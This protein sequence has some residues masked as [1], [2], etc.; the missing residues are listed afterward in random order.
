MLNV[1]SNAY[2]Q[3][4]VDN[5]N[6]YIHQQ[7]YNE[8]QDIYNSPKLFAR[9]V[10]DNKSWICSVGAPIGEDYNSIYVPHYMLEQIN[11]MGDGEMLEVDILPAETFDPTTK[12]TLQP[13]TSGF[14][15]DDIQE[16]LSNELTKLGILQKNTTIYIYNSEINMEIAYNVVDLEPA[17]ISLCDGDDVSLDFIESLDTIVRPP[18]PFPEETLPEL[19]LPSA[20]M[21][22][23]PVAHSVTPT[24]P[25]MEEKVTQQLNTVTHREKFNPW[26]NKEFKP[27]MS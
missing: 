17:S 20:P 13:H 2:L 27:T 3:V 19:L 8:L 15:T 11:C 21:I 5:Y 9:I 23:E 7:K 4:E 1:Y 25:M 12:I 24:A 22:E 14:Q 10:K 26:R 6:C 16:L 18:T